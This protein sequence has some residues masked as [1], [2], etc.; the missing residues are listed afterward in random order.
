M[1]NNSYLFS[2][3]KLDE[4]MISVVTYKRTYNWTSVTGF[5]WMVHQ[6]PA[7]E[8]IRSLGTNSVPMGF[9]DHLGGPA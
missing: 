2:K 4:E 9:W 8:T 3:E 5:T 6:F 1:N 7:P